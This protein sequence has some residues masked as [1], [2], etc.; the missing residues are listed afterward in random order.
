MSQK[1]RGGGG[2]IGGRGAP[3]FSIQS[4]LPVPGASLPL[5]PPADWHSTGPWHPASSLLTASP[6]GML[7][8]TLCSLSSPSPPSAVS[9]TV[10][11][12]SPPPALPSHPSFS[13]EQVFLLWQITKLRPVR[14]S[15]LHPCPSNAQGNQ[16]TCRALPSPLPAPLQT[17]T[18]GKLQVL[19][20]LFSVPKIFFQLGLLFHALFCKQPSLL[21]CT[22]DVSPCQ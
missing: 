15:T 6:S 14:L 3:C 22:T 13:L 7:L 11:P 1:N 16:P 8:P 9:L 19:P 5:S 21:N 17:P 10:T 18:K 20:D 4:P 12:P 2:G